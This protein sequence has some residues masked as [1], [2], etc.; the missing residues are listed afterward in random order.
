MSEQFKFIIIYSWNNIINNLIK[1]NVIYIILSLIM[2]YILG[3]IGDTLL[4]L[5]IFN[6]VGYI[7][8]LLSSMFVCYRF[9]KWMKKEEK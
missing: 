2:F 1:Y 3:C 5:N 6:D 8:Y 9:F 4:I 7:I